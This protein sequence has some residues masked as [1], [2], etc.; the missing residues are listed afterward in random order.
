MSLGLH[1]Q[2]PF[3]LHVRGLGTGRKEKRGH[4]CDLPTLCCHHALTQRLLLARHSESKPHCP[5][6]GRPE[7][8]PALR[9]GWLPQLRSLPSPHFHRH[10]PILGAQKSG[11]LCSQDT[12]WFPGPVSAPFDELH[13]IFSQDGAERAKKSPTYLLLL[14]KVLPRKNPLALNLSNRVLEPESLR[15]G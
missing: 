3:F 10:Q 15:A 12:Q 8:R 6:H 13:P 7:T 9:R 4:C 2:D 5:S 14:H 11:H 1:Y